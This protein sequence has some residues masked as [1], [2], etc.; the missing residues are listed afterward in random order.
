MNNKVVV[1]R[2]WHKKGKA[3]YFTMLQLL[4][5]FPKIDFEFHIVLDQPEYQD[6]WSNKIDNLPFKCNWYSKEDMHEYLKDNNYCGD[7][8][9]SKIPNFVH[10]YHIIINHYVR[11]KYNYDYCLMIEY[12]VIFNNPDL[13]QLE[14]C[15]TEKIPFGIVEPHNPGCDKALAS[16]MEQIFGQ[17]IV[18]F[19][20]T[21]INAG[22]KGLNLSIFDYFLEPSTFPHL[23]SMFDFSGIYNED[24]SEKTGWERTIIDTQEQ[25]FHSLMNALS[26]KYELLDPKKYYVFP[27]WVD[28]GYLSKSKVIH[29]IGHEKPKEMYNLI[30][31]LTLK[32]EKYLSLKCN[33]KELIIS[34][35]NRDYSWV[36]NLNKDIKVTIYNKSDDIKDN[37]IPLKNIGRDVHTFFTHLVNNYDNLAD[38]TFFSQDFPFDHV[39]N[40]VEIINSGVKNWTKYSLDNNGECFFFCTQHPRF[41]C[42]L[43]GS[44]AHPGLD[45]NLAWKRVFGD[46][47]CP[48]DIIFTP[49]GHL[50]IAKECVHRHP[51]SFYENIIKFLEERELAPWEIERLEPYIFGIRNNKNQEMFR[52]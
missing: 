11:K 15:L 34:A 51:K 30:D 52:Q 22:F 41:V 21:G 12:D 14:K 43:D 19:P 6:E 36:N 10:F 38:I 2:L 29:F 31:V 49:T 9:I 28:M 46:V 23:I 17:S 1:S 24:G 20:K 18:K 47:S 40:Y 32:Y 4:F 39:S 3:E 26:S 37:E 25:S 50:A 48:N 35:Y 5:H 7:D 44:P 27:Y 42:R 33:T 16:K 13:S 8:L 45:L